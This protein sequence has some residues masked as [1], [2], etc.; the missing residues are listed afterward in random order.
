SLTAGVS[1]A[2]VEAARRRG[3]PD[4]PS[5]GD[6]NT[7]TGA[8]G[9]PGAG[10]ATDV[11]AAVRG[12][13]IAFQ[14][15]MRLLPTDLRAL[16]DRDVDEPRV[17]DLLAG[18]LTVT[19]RG[20]DDRLLTP[21]VPPE[22]TLPELDLV[23]PFTGGT[24]IEVA[25][26]D[27]ATRSVL[28]RPGSQ[29]PALLA[30]GRVSEVLADAARRLRISGFRHVIHPVGAT[31]DGARLAAVLLLRVPDDERVAALSRVAV[32]PEPRRTPQD[33]EVPA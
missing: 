20:T 5:G 8:E 1:R 16:L 25:T 32:L 9:E 15:G 23:L 22:P 3:F 10:A 13:R 30:A 18:L 2:L 31:V 4:A 7:A 14:R 27:G 33:Q 19:W 29:W 24:A 26:E 28:L 21:R 11:R 6:S 17:A 12:A